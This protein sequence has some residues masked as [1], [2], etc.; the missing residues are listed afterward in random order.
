MYGENCKH[1]EKGEEVSTQRQ[2]R[3]EFECADV[4]VAV[5]I[6]ALEYTHCHYTV[7]IPSVFGCPTECPLVGMS[8]CNA[9]GHCAYDTDIQSARCFCDEGY[10]GDDCSLTMAETQEVAQKSGSLTGLIVTLFVL[11]VLLVGAVLM[12]YKQV[13]AY[14]EDNANYMAL[15]GGDMDGDT[16]NG[17]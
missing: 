15:A 16:I 8:L 1:N 10:T 14:K 7:T 6:H 13:S 2:F 3:L 9:K 17:V 5:P 4:A 11:I 12:M